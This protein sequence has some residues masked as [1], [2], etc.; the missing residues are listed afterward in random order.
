MYIKPGDDKQ[1]STDVLGQS[2]GPGP[3]VV[4]SSVVGSS[5]VGSSVVGSSVV[6]SSVVGA[7]VIG[8]SVGA[9]V[10]TASPQLIGSRMKGGVLSNAVCCPPEVRRGESWGL[11]VFLL[12]Y[13]PLV[14]M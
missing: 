7:S 12:Q 4:G 11:G 5:V 8:G 3:S 13:L 2:P 10:V 6:G 9:G 1:A 14:N